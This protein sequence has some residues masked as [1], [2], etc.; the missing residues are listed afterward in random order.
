MDTSSSF[1]QFYIVESLR[2]MF[3]SCVINDRSQHINRNRVR[4]HQSQSNLCTCNL[5]V[6]SASAVART[7]LISGIFM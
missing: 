6:F 4:T 2:R 3:F 5:T 1:A 7:L